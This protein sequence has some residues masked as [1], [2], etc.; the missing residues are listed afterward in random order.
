MKCNEIEPLIYLIKEG[1]LTRKE[2]TDLE[3]HLSTCAD[4][5][6]LYKS[7]LQM[8]SLIGQSKFMFDAEHQAEKTGDRV[9]HRIDRTKYSGLPVYNLYDLMRL[10]KVIA[11][12][13]LFFL[14]LTFA[15]QQTSFHRNRAALQHRVNE[16]LLISGEEVRDADCVNELKRKLRARNRSTFPQADELTF[17]KISEKQLT[18]YI[19]QV[20]GA[21][22]ADL[23]S[24]KRLLKQAGLTINNSTN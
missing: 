1:E 9:M 4:C 20:C 5:R 13:L 14:A 12:S 2:K 6:K 24:I 18:Q 11:A 17:N 8:T 7:V 15:L 22:T 19:S 3:K 23:N 10:T 16:T 21:N